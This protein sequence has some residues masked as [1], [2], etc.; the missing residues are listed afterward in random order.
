MIHTRP[1]L[2]LSQYNPKNASDRLFL[3]AISMWI[4][5]SLFTQGPVSGLNNLL[6]FPCPQTLNAPGQGKNLQT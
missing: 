3:R 4:I 5:G 6:S 1:F 2:L